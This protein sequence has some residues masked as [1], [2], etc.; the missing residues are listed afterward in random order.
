M[1]VATSMLLVIYVVIAA[2]IAVGILLLGRPTS[3]NFVRSAIRAIA[4]L[5]VAGGTLLTTAIAG[6]QLTGRLGPAQ[7]WFRSPAFFVGLAILLGVAIW[8]FRRRFEHEHARLIRFGLPALAV[9]ALGLIVVFNRFDR[10]SAPMSAFMPTMRTEAPEIRFEEA[11]GAT[12]NLSDFRGKVVLVNFWA[13][14]CVPC[15]REMPMLSAAQT[16]FKRDGLV[17]I[18]LSLEEPDVLADFL[19]ANHFDGMQGRLTK[20]DDYYH[21]GQIYPLSYLISRDGRVVKRW[22]GR[23]AE[24]WL[25]ESIREEL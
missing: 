19:R 15:R 17:V 24:N 16:E 6:L 7:V 5:L 13:T 11:G 4:W 21:A 9:I 8:W 23:P 25:Q 14:W 22:S 3:E 2:G 1:E 12:R 18:Y 10:R 20:A